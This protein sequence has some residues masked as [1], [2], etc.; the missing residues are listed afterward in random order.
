MQ[1]TKFILTI[2]LNDKDTKQQ[3]YDLITSYKLVEDIC[4]NY[5]DGYTIYECKGGYKHDNGYFVT[6]ISLRLELQFTTELTVK[7][8]ANEIKK[9]LNQETIVFEKLTS[10]SILI[11]VTEKL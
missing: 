8:I 1:N 11:W 2:G 7:I 5:V 6:E 3:K 4:K 9:V 10:N